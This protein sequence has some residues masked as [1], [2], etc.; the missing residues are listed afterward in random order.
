MNLEQNIKDVIGTKL[1]DGTIEKIIS[2]KLEKG[3]NEA[4]EDLFRSY[5]DVGKT[6]KDKVKEVLIPAIEKHNFSDHIVKLDTV[7]TE[8]VNST[9]LIENKT[10]L[11]NFKDLMIE[12]D[13]K[14]IKTSYLFEKWCEFVA[15]EVETNGLEVNSDDGNPTYE[16]V[17]CTMEV[18]HV[19]GR[20]WSDFEKA[21]IIFECE[22]DEKLNFMVPISRWSKF[23]GDKWSIDYSANPTIESLKYMNEFEIFLLKIKRSFVKLTVDDEYSDEEVTPEA[24]PE[25]SFS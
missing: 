12:E 4:M 5:G 17:N 1:S 8:I 21:N 18:E 16:P 20:S 10:L 2:E 23:D 7:L 13:I 19:G 14:V 3:I 24:E 25:I 6:I 9:A 11:E 15:K 22:H